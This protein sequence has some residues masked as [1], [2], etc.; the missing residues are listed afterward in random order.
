MGTP[1]LKAGWRYMAMASYTVDPAILR[2][3]LPA[4]TELDA[5]AGHDIVSVAGYL[6]QDAAVFGLRIPFHGSFEEVN[7]R[8]YVRR[9]TPGGWRRGAV[10]V[11]EIVPH[12]MV[13]WASRCAYGEPCL[14]LP[15]RHAIEREDAKVRVEYGWR[16]D[17]AWESLKLQAD[18]IPR[19][20]PAGSLEEFIAEHAWGYAARPGGCSEYRVEHPRWTFWPATAASLECDA[21]ALCG[22]EFAEF[23]AAPPAGAFIADGSEVAVGHRSPCLVEEPGGLIADP[24]LPGLAN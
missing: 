12:R 9:K 4:G 14:A 18:G 15:M 22:P 23:L 5:F 19:R 1:F 7:L 21:A 11:R 20:S 6:C 13:A 24:S 2:P 10:L 8:F 17:G 16:R 3:L